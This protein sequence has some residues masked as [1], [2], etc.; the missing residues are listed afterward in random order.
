MWGSGTV[1]LKIL[2]LMRRQLIDAWQLLSCFLDIIIEK[3]QAL[4]DSLSIPSFR[5]SAIWFSASCPCTGAALYGDQAMIWLSVSLIL[6]W[7]RSRNG[8]SVQFG[9]Q[10]HQLLEPCVSMHGIL[11]CQVHLL[12]GDF[13][14]LVYRD[15]VLPKKVHF[16]VVFNLFAQLLNQNRTDLYCIKAW[17]FL[18]VHIITH[19]QDTPCASLYKQ[20]RV[21]LG[22]RNAKDYGPRYLLFVL[23]IPHPKSNVLWI[24]VVLYWQIQTH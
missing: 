3:N 20:S 12:E 21:L 15:P 24:A 4:S 1:V 18:R 22:K 16:L 6:W 2:L 8:E 13:G 10:Y 9:R 5:T 19:T 11:T 17:F 23:K 14:I 7:R